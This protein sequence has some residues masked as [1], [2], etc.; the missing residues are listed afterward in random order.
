MRSA[1]HLSLG[2][3]LA[4]GVVLGCARDVAPSDPAAPPTLE[5]AGAS[6]IR[7]SLRRSVTTSSPAGS[8]SAG[9]TD[10]TIWA[11]FD[12][13]GWALASSPDAGTPG[14]VGATSRSD[15]DS[16]DRSRYASFVDDAG[17]LHEMDVI[18][19]TPGPPTSVVYKR[20]RVV[21]FEQQ[22]TWASVSGGWVLQSE[23]AT[24]HL[25]TGTD[26]RIGVDALGMQVARAGFPRPDLMQV[27]AWMAGLLQPKPLAAQMYFRECTSDWLTW[28]GAA[29][30]AE[31]YWVKFSQSKNPLDF[32]RALA[33]TTGAGVAL[34][35][36]V[37][38]MIAHDQQ[39]DPGG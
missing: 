8:E 9:V 27:G 32:K 7:A 3:L 16:R 15:F 23:R 33:A 12:A 28:T 21:V 6:G 2:L 17:V 31:Y 39:L 38:C 13:D 1:V 35:G 25:G 24:Y 19:E 10:T 22:A 29:L 30:L 11:P 18:A 36:L 5:L 14:A 20:N 34:N 37:D 4:C 26:L